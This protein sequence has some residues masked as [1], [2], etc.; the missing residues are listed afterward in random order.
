MK[1]LAIILYLFGASHAIPL[2]AQRLLSASNSNEV[3]LGVVN[4]NIPQGGAMNLFVPGMYQPPLQQ[5]IAGLPQIPFNARSGLNAQLPNQVMSYVVP[6]GIP[7][8]QGQMQ[9]VP[10]YPAQQQ[11][12][13]ASPKQLGNEPPIEQVFGCIVPQ[14]NGEVVMPASGLQLPTKNPD[15]LLGD[16]NPTLVPNNQEDKV[17]TEV[18]RAP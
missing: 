7:Q 4:P 2:V 16:V 12:A 8:K 18:I 15:D 10:L 14:L 6:Y 1:I 9:I 3:L 11:P 5:K 13:Q 17:T